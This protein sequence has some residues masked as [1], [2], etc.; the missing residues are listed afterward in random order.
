MRKVPSS[1]IAIATVA[2]SWSLFACSSTDTSD[3]TT[4]DTDTSTTDTGSADTDT[5]D[6]TDTGGSTDSSGGSTGTD[7]GGPDGQGLCT[8]VEACGGDVIGTWVIAESCVNMDDEDEGMS[9]DDMCPGMTMDRGMQ[10]SG[11]LTFNDDGTYAAV[12]SM[13][14]FVEM[15]VPGSC[16]QDMPGGEEMTCRDLGNMMSGGGPG[17]PDDHDDHDGH[18]DHDDADDHGHDHEDDHGDDHGDEHMDDDM[19]GEIV[20]NCEDDGNGGCNCSGSQVMNEVDELGTYTVADNMIAGEANDGD[21][22]PNLSYCRDGDV[23]EAA[24]ID[25]DTGMPVFYFKMNLQ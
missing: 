10:A 20:L 7:D 21:G 24:Q 2:L 6:S 12:L 13:E 25:E 8:E 16:F 19:G 23:M 3:G 17:G 11:Q 5:T 22:G 1:L 15:S 9:E 14:M 4:G 18:D